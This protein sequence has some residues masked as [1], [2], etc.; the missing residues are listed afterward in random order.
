MDKEKDKETNPG[1]GTLN[2][3]N[4]FGDGRF[5]SVMFFPYFHSCF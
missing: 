4:M 3:I 2:G 1:V 5:G